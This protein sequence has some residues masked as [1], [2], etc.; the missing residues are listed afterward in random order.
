MPSIVTDEK[1]THLNLGEHK[2]LRETAELIL[3]FY[4]QVSC[5]FK[6]SLRSFV[7]DHVDSS[8]PVER[9]HVFYVHAHCLRR[10]ASNLTVQTRVWQNQNYSLVKRHESFVI[11]YGFVAARPENYCVNMHAA[12]GII[13]SYRKR[14][15]LNWTTSLSTVLL[16]LSVYFVRSTLGVFRTEPTRLNCETQNTRTGPLQNTVS[17]IGDTHK[18]GARFQKASILLRPGHVFFF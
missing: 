3:P 4:S 15:E 11:P 10:F 18:S 1:K 6:R 8:N 2:F 17:Y 14:S 16:G 12:V 9:W 13:I 7:I 5:G